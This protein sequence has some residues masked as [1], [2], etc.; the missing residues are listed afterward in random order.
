MY[1][2]SPREPLYERPRWQRSEDERGAGNADG[3]RETKLNIEQTQ[4][5]EHI[6]RVLFRA[7]SITVSRHFDD[8]GFIR[9]LWYMFR[10]GQ[11]RLSSSKLP[12]LALALAIRVRTLTAHAQTVC[13]LVTVLL[14]GHMDP[15]VLVVDVILCSNK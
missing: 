11:L 13:H 1:V 5:N 9:H 2:P 10:A 6:K 3:G 15:S 14:P 7:G 4:A 12:P 8:R